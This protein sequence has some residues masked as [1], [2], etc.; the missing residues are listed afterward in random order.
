MTPPASSATVAAPRARRRRPSDGH[1]AQVGTGAAAR[2]ARR[3]SGPAGGAHALPRPIGLPAQGARL[4]ARLRALPDHRFVDRLLRGRVWIPFVALFLCG[5]VATQV[6]LLKLNAGISR[7]V[8]TSSTLQRENAALRASIGRLSSGDRLH[9]VANH[10]GL[11]D[12]PAGSVQFL[13]THPGDARKAA[14]SMSKPEPGTETRD[15]AATTST[16]TTTG[17]TPSTTGTSTAGTTATGTTPSTTTG[18]TPSTTT[19]TTPSTTTGTTP[20]TTGTSTAGTTAAGTT[21][22]SAAAP[23]TPSPSAGVTPATSATS[24]TTAPGVTR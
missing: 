7:A 20:S 5:I 9:T 1:R 4:G 12:P 3:M 10:L 17:T 18:T 13:R 23:V 24:A 8:E 2:P 11:V 15:A 14:A 22:S 21:P 6:H 16:P 19:G